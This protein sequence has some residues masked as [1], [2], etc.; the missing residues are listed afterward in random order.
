MTKK[1][2]DVKLQGKG[3]HDVAYIRNPAVQLRGDGN[4]IGIIGQAANYQ[5]EEFV[6]VEGMYA[7]I[8]MSPKD[9]MLL[10]KGLQD[11]ALDQG[12]EI[13]DTEGQIVEVPG[14]RRKH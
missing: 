2:T 7:R 3:I 4:V 13:P 10:L 9:A 6:P 8:S 14:D 1:T 11:L 5:E 12:Y